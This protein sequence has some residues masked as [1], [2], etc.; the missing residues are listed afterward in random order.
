MSPPDPQVRIIQLDAATL[1]ALGDGDLDLARASSP[2]P[3]T[4]YLAGPECRGVWRRRAE[5]VLS[6]PEDAPW[7]TGV[8]VDEDTRRAVGAAGFHAAPDLEGMV[9][10]GYRID[11]A[12]RRRGYARATLEALMQRARAE[13]TAR[14]FRVTISPDNL[15]SLALVTSGYGFVEVGEQ[16]DDEDGLEIIYELSVEQ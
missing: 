12:L 11:P 16:W 14:T 3:L 5:Q 15:P 13:P 1:A 2:A 6:T 9:E 4:D 10:V 8:L 7:V